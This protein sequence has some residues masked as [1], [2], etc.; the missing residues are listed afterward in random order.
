MRNKELQSLRYKLIE[1]RK[2]KL[3]D[4]RRAETRQQLLDIK[5]IFK[6]RGIE[7]PASL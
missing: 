4:A 3:D 2:G 5:G 1:E 7:Y 6:R